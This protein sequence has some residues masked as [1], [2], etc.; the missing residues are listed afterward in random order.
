M[1]TNKDSDASERLTAVVDCNQV[2]TKGGSSLHSSA[3]CLVGD[4]K[5]QLERNGKDSKT[6]NTRDY[7]RNS[8]YHLTKEEM[9]HV[10]LDED[11]GCIVT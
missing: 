2:K 7:N 8:S 3:H 10:V 4:E 1:G 11:N 6:N 9:K 5:S